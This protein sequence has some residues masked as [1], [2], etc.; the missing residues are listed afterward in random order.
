MG[1]YKKIDLMR[2]YDAILGGDASETS[3]TDTNGAETRI[4]IKNTRLF[5]PLEKAS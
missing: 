4:L 3:S 1:Q 2:F 5:I